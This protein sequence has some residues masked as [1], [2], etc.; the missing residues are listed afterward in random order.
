MLSNMTRL[1]RHQ[2]PMTKEG[3]GNVL[4]PM[5]GGRDERGSGWA[6]YVW[7]DVRVALHHEEVKGKASVG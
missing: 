6:L 2:N 4:M 7:N 5:A 3:A 1:A